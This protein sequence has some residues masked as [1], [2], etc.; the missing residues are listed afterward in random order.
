MEKT[1]RIMTQA[2]PYKSHRIPLRIIMCSSLSWFVM[3]NGDEIKPLLDGLHFIGKRYSHGLGQVVKWEIKEA[4]ENKS[5]L[6]DGRLMR[7]IPFDRNVKE[8]IASDSWYEAELAIRPPY[9]HQS[10]VRKCMVPH[11]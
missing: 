7:N 2:G 6:H 5:V 1:K 9:W 8:Q 4:P 10:R 3:G 11:R